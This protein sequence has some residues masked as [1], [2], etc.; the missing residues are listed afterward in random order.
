MKKALLLATL[1]VVSVAVAQQSPTGQ[2]PTA[3]NGGLIQNFNATLAGAGPNNSGGPGLGRHDLQNANTLT[4]LGCESCHLPHT[5]PMY[6][7][8][9]LWAWSNVPALVTTY[10]TDTNPTGM[11]L[12]PPTVGA[13]NTLRSGN[14][15]SMLCLTCHDGATASANGI[16]GAVT[17]SGA[18]FPLLTSSAGVGDMGAQ[19][20]VDAVV[21]VTTDFQQPVPVLGSVVGMNSASA[22]IGND[23]LPLWD[24][25]FRVQC[26]TCHDQHN[27]Y[28][29]NQGA[30]GG[31][32]F[33]RVANTNGTY[34]CRQC[35]NK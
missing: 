26:T 16:I 30:A 15:R 28:Q 6:G 25:D 5:A 34:L 29:S 22:T 4:P 27:D 17:S 23:A 9:F 35:H 20:P 12:T 2:G 21:P 11:L 32:P 8:T 7:R 19:H 31:V 33:L 14:T 24:V 1:L 3:L 13:Y 18:P 10:Q